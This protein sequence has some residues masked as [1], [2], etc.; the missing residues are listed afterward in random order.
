MHINGAGITGVL[1]VKMEGSLAGLFAAVH[2][3]SISDSQAQ[4]AALAVRKKLA[5]MGKF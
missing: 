5:G 1:V 2:S 3:G 4:Q